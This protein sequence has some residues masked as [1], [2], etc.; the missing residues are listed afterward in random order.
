MV[1]ISLACACELAPSR[2]TNRS[3]IRKTSTGSVRNQLK[4]E[5][6]STLAD[7][8]A[9]QAARPGLVTSAVIGLYRAGLV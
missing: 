3:G 7:S 6:A 2:S 8:S 5:L 1:F 9:Y 4:N